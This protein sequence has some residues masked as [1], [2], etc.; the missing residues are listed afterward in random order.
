EERQGNE[1][2][3]L[4]RKREDR[5]HDRTGEERSTQEVDRQHRGLALQLAAGQEVAGNCSSGQLN[6]GQGRGAA[7]EAA[8]SGDQTAKGGAVQDSA[9]KVEACTTDGGFGQGQPAGNEHQ[10]PQRYVD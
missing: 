8:Q 3:K 2:Q 9:Y 4:G 6:E 7:A 1:G 10:Q 5:G